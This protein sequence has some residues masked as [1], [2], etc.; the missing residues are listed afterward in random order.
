MREAAAGLADVLTAFML[1]A[2]LGAPDEIAAL[3][4]TG[5]RGLGAAS[6]QVWLADQEHRSLFRI[7][8]PPEEAQPV[9][10]TMAGR[11]FISGDVVEVERELGGMAAWLPLADGTNRMGVLEVAI[12]EASEGTRERLRVFAAVAAAKMTVRAQYSDFFT[13]VRRR[14]PMSLAGELQW[15]LLPPSSF[16]TADVSIAGILEPAYDVGGDA[17]DHAS[18]AGMLEFAIFDAVGH[19]LDASIVCSLAVGAYRNQRRAAAGL[20]ETARFIDRTIAERFS[21]ARFTTAQLGQLDLATGVLRIINAGHPLP[22]IFRNDGYIG[23][24]ACPP[25]VPLGIGNAFGLDPCEPFETQL[26]PGDAL[27]LYSDGVVEARGRTGIDFGE[28]RLIEFV[29]RAIASGLPPTECLRRLSHAVY[30]YN[31]GQLQDDATMLM[32]QWH[33]PQRPSPVLEAPLTE[34]PGDR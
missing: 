29:H 28:D 33:P 5:V 13:R 27:L 21:T 12:D 34:D 22:L 17:F 25:C 26:E 24:L 6:G 1:D 20:Q 3:V 7:F 31:E 15:Q 18:Q 30:D 14:R 11:A 4:A 2:H 8:P 16:S 10:G 32:L 23:S 9:E 19:D